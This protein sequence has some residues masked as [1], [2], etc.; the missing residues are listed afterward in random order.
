MQVKRVGYAEARCT[1][2]SDHRLAVVRPVLGGLQL[3]A[4]RGIAEVAPSQSAFGRLLRS[5]QFLRKP[6]ESRLRAG[7]P[8]L[9]VAR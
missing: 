1:R 6:A 4:P 2:D 3:D 5:A 7:L 9:R 8:A